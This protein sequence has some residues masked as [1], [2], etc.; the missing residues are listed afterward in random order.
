[1]S[2]PKRKTK[3]G[4]KLPL[5]VFCATENWLRPLVPLTENIVS[6]GGLTTIESNRRLAA[7][8]LRA[9][10]TRPQAIEGKYRLVTMQKK[11]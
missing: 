5:D 4:N 6:F 9:V 2:R 8:L 10:V 7:Q 1:M 3:L 11:N